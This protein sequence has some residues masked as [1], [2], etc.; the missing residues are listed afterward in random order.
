ML[1]R[2]E[3]IGVVG[4]LHYEEKAAA[5]LQGRDPT[6]ARAPA[7]ARGAFAARRWP[8]ARAAFQAAFPAA[9]QAVA[10]SREIRLDGR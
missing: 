10:V 2:A 6:P 7:A 5:D 8:A 4:G 3:M 9:Y 1:A